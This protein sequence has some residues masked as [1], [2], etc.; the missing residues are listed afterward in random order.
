MNEKGK[1]GN[2]MSEDQPPF[3]YESAA[4]GIVSGF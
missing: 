1:H 3:K 4:T 2:S